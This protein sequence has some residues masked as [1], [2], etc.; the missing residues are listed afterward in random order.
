LIVLADCFVEE[1]IQGVELSVDAH[2]LLQRRIARRS[3]VL[4]PADAARPGLAK[5]A[6]PAKKQRRI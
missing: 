1:G 5:G 6:G 4:A 3:D 2:A